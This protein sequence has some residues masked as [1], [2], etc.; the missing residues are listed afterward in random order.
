M[1]AV[2]ILNCHNHAQ[3]PDHTGQAHPHTLPHAAQHL[4]A[5]L[6]GPPGGGPRG[7]LHATLALQKQGMMQAAWGGGVFVEG[8]SGAAACF[9]KVCEAVWGVEG[10]VCGR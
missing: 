6:A 3:P 9:V 10:K 8:T 1:H 2:H 4:L 5:W 7:V